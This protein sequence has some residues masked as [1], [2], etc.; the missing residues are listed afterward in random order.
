MSKY[1]PETYRACFVSSELKKKTR[2][3]FHSTT[4]FSRYCFVCYERSDGNMEKRAYHCAPADGTR[5]PLCFSK[6]S[7]V[8]YSVFSLQILV[9]F[10]PVKKEI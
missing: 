5:L 1:G 10:R 7:L 3:I 9:F 6:R 2:N 8:F 4:E